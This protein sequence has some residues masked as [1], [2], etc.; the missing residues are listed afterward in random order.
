MVAGETE[1]VNKFKAWLWA[2]RPF[3]ISAAIVPVLAG[4]S[5]AFRDGTFNYIKFILLLIA[6]ILVQ[7]TTNLVDE[8]SDHV[9]PEGG[10]KLLAPYKV[11]AKGVLTYREVKRGAFICLAAAAVIGIYFAVVTGWPVAAMCIASA[12]AVYF[13]SAGPKPLGKIGL[14][15]PLVFFYMGILMVTGTYYVQT[16]AFT[17]DSFLLSLPVGCTVTAILAANDIRDMEEDRAAGKKS[18]GTILGHRAAWCEFLVLITLAFLIVILLAATGRIS[19]FALIS[20]LALPQ[21]VSAVRLL[22]PGRSRSELAPGVPST[23]RLHLLL[24]VLLSAGIVLGRLV[25]F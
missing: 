25:S 4:C 10:K 22:A 20:L 17:I 24:G 21:A 15:Q 11:I 14:G 9:R 6:G 1:S 2:V 12:L 8:Y 7:I 3:T 19:L 5:L 18:I 23:S 16:R 13:Y